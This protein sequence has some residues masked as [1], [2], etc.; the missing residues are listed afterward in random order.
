MVCKT[1]KRVNYGDGEQ[2]RKTS[3]PDGSFK[4]E[5]VARSSAVSSRGGF[6]KGGSSAMLLPVSTII[7]CKIVSASYWYTRGSSQTPDLS[8]VVDKGDLDAV[9]GAFCDCLH[10]CRKPALL[11]VWEPDASPFG[12]VF[13]H[14]RG[15][16]QGQSRSNLS[17]HPCL[18]KSPKRAL[19]LALRWLL[20][21]L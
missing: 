1:G 6:L 4:W 9:L 14:C 19:A 15:E 21:P 8:A 7:S 18:R 5:S 11:L 17:P 2:T 3:V 16:V 10:F 12:I 20:H 13:R